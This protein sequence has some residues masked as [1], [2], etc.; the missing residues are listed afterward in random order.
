MNKI[1]K[2]LQQGF[3]VFVKN[4]ARSL[5]TVFGISIGIAMVILVLS[6]GNGVKSIVM[7]EIASF[8]DNWINIE[9]K[10]PT[11]AKN[12]S[13]N[14]TA[15]AQGVTIT[16]LTL[17][18]KEAIVALPS[19]KQAYAG[20]TSQTIIS[21]DIKKENA[22]IFGVS[23]EYFLINQGNINKGFAYTDEDDKK[24]AQV[25]VLGSTIADTLFGNQEV[26]GETVKLNG[27]G[28]RVVGVMETLGASGFMDMDSIIYLPV[29]TV[30]QKIMGVKHVLWV[31]AD[32]EDEVENADYV[33]EEITA[34][35]RDRHNIDSPDKDDFAVTTLA[36]SVEIVDTIL[37]GITWLLIALSAISLAVGGVGI[38]NIMYVSV[39]ERTFEIG[40]RK[41]VGATPQDIKNQFLSEAIVITS[42]GGIVGIVV[43]VFLSFMVSLIAGKIGIDWPFYVSIMSVFLSVTF[44]ITVG[45][46]FGYYPAKQAATLDAI[47]ALRK[48]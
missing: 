18:D 40:L 39:A 31:V 30:Q 13:E 20:L 7:G 34:I 28:Y 9:V 43:G 29:S 23:S 11:A 14:S 5:L 42:I 26:I 37:L 10:I 33:A 16:T 17:K 35:L 38:M 24:G 27:K 45:V 15:I 46:V 19:V 44:A 48:E 21:N 4:K 1:I 47:S 2:F 6:A 12:S 32:L 25:V 8:G 22:T 36:E 41:A 3:D